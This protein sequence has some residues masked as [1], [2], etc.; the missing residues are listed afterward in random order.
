MSIFYF[1]NIIHI[2]I[3]RHVIL[4]WIIVFSHYLKVNYYLEN[5]FSHNISFIKLKNQGLSR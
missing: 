5:Y 3:I 4:V 1:I 2:P